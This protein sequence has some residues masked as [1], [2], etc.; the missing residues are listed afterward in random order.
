MYLSFPLLSHDLL[1]HFLYVYFQK[2][3]QPVIQQKVKLYQLNECT[4]VLYMHSS[5]ASNHELCKSVII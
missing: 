3:T 2:L 1:G 4:K 5:L